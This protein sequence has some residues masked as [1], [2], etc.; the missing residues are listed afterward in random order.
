MV[1][2]SNQWTS[3]SSQ[4]FTQLSAGYKYNTLHPKKWLSLKSQGH[5]WT[6]LCD[7]RPLKPEPYHVRLTVGGDCLDYD[8]DNA[9]P[10]ADLIDTKLIINSTIY[11]SG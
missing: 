7:H 3:T 6:F 9:S 5:L 1:D 2:G 10:A 4:W 8:E 11:D